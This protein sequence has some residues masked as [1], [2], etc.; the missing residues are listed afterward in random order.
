MVG[1]SRVYGRMDRLYS[2]LEEVMVGLN[3]D[4]AWSEEVMV[5]LN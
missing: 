1:L 5:G 3:R 4:T 2:R